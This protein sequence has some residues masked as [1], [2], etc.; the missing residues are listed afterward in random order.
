MNTSFALLARFESPIVELKHICD[1]FFG[2]TPG[3]AEQQAKA[4]DL[5]VP[6]FKLRESKR[7]PTMVMIS[8]LADYIDSQ[9]K[10][11]RE[12]WESVNV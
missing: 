7:C 2:I 3:T 8:D 4:C 5:P 10:Q 1:E 9:Y 6:T 11:A 12:E